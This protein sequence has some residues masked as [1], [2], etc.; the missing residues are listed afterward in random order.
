MLL[1]V[2]HHR[3]AK[4]I[5]TAGFQQ[6]GGSVAIAVRDGAD[7]RYQLTFL[8]VLLTDQEL[9]LEQLVVRFLAYLRD[10]FVHDPNFSSAK[11]LSAIHH[12]NLMDDK[13]TSFSEAQPM[14]LPVH[15]FM[16]KLRLFLG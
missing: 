6:L 1:R 4:P 8:W 12:K 13:Y 10:E 14:F 9:R 15:P 2:L 16:L 11:G 7:E 5:V 3:L